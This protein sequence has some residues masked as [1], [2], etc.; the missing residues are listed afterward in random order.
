MQG[1]EDN[2]RIYDF[3]DEAVILFNQLVQIFA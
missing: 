3:L 2:Q 1:F